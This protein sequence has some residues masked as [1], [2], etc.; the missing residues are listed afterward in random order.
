V[1]PVTRRP[2]ARSRAPS[3]AAWL[4]LAALL[5]GC[6]SAQDASN[7]R[8]TPGREVS[9]HLEALRR[10][11]ELQERIP[12]LQRFT[13]LTGRFAQPHLAA[14]HALREDGSSTSR[15]AL[16]AV[17]AD[18]AF[19]YR[20][21]AALAL[22]AV[23]DPASVD[24][25]LGA[26]GASQPE[27]RR[28]AVRS[29]GRFAAAGLLRD[30]AGERVL[31]VLEE[32]YRNESEAIVRAALFLTILDIGSRRAFEMA[33][34]LSK[35]DRDPVVRCEVLRARKFFALMA[36]SRDA[37]AGVRRHT[38]SIVMELAAV[39]EPRTL[40]RA[41][42]R[43]RSAR[44]DLK[45]HC[46]DLLVEA[47]MGIPALEDPAAPRLLAGLARAGAPRVRAAALKALGR[48]E[49]AASLRAAI[50]ALDDPRWSVRRAA[51]EVLAGLEAPEAAEALVGTLR[52]GAVLDRREAARA[53]ARVPGGSEALVSAF[54]DPMVLVRTAAE[55]ALLEHVQRTGVAAWHLAELDAAR[56]QADEVD[57]AAAEASRR[58]ERQAA[59]WNP[60]RAEDEA[61]L[62]AALSHPD[63]RVG[64]RAARV[65]AA[66][67]GE[68]TR[69]RLV[70]I[71]SE[72]DPAE[73]ELAAFALGLRGE[74]AAR[75][76]LERA[77][78]G[79]HPGVAAAAVRALQDLDAGDSLP[80]L[81]ALAWNAP[82]ERVR[83]AA[84]LASAMVH[85]VSLPGRRT[86]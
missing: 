47:I 42:M 18:P 45:G 54:A 4:C 11:A 66:S 36:G 25:L 26:L 14:I 75:E 32:R 41:R 74:L 40:E 28:T 83:S 44:L 63:P 58:A 76:A 2:S 49:G 60:A 46:P 16:I 31:D 13:H 57:A 37:L 15:S 43:A 64:R 79:D 1:L 34:R 30:E 3:R 33:F 67:P 82:S 24:P 80:L 21:D 6:A 69:A 10:P 56:Q 51:I 19:P 55:Y 62:I 48:L 9:D 17:L 22:G 84:Q 73:A 68:A 85:P 7:G 29:L 65:L 35:D 86:P 78:L 71:L 39:D 8:P 12:W 20:A 72:A 81:R 53:L 61:A 23:P 27:V 52:E 59:L 38:R 77:A 5:L 70:S 50:E